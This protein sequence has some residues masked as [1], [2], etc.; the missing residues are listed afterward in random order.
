MSARTRK[1]SGTTHNVFGIQVGVCITLL[2]KLPG[3]PKDVNRSAKIFYHAVPR[4]WR[5][6]K[7]YEFL[8]L[9][10]CIGGVTWQR[11]KPDKKQN[12]L[13]LGYKQEFDGFMPIGDRDFVAGNTSQPVF[14]HYSRGVSTSRD[15]TAVNF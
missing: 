8:E 6:E 3:K 12:W 15:D 2:V 9:K 4:D 5:R 13:D 7:K 14:S 11:L 10:R 1:L